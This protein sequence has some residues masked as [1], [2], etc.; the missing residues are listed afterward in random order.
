MSFEDF[1]VAFKK[2]HAKDY[3]GQASVYTP[4]PS[5]VAET[6]PLAPSDAVKVPVQDRQMFA[7]G[8]DWGDWD[9]VKTEDYTE[10]VE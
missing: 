3:M 7:A 2:R 1:M 9:G 4:K 8:D 6:K 10:V 5:K